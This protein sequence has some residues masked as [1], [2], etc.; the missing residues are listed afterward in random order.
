MD[1]MQKIRII[2]RK[3]LPMPLN[4]R[5]IEKSDGAT[6][7]AAKAFLP[8]MNVHIMPQ[9]NPE[10]SNKKNMKNTLVNPGQKVVSIGNSF[11]NTQPEKEARNKTVTEVRRK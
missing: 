1:R 6:G 3:L 10:N 2:A 11:V 7:A 5:S 8:G 4:I 9:R